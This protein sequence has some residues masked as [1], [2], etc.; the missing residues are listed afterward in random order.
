[1]YYVVYCRLDFMVRRVHIYV[2]NTFG[3]RATNGAI[4]SYF[5]V[6]SNNIDF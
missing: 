3:T 4:L 5:V 1:M 2:V 6:V